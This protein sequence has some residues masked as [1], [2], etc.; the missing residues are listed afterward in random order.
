MYQYMLYKKRGGT[1]IILH[2]VPNILE[3]ALV[4]RV[5]R[6]CYLTTSLQRRELSIGLSAVGRHYHAKQ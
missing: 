5:G 6:F 4:R 2:R 3:L 1:T